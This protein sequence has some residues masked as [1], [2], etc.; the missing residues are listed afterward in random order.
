[1]K[2]EMRI[3]FSCTKIDDATEDGLGA[4]VRCRKG[5]REI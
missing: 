3:I 2:C 1:M 4:M 5:C